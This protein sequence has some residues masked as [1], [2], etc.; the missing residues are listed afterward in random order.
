[1]L[2]FVVLYF[3]FYFCVKDKLSSVTKYIDF[4]LFLC[5]SLLIEDFECIT[6]LNRPCLIELDALNKKRRK[7]F[8]RLELPSF[9][10]KEYENGDRSRSYLMEHINL[11]RTYKSPEISKELRRFIEE[12]FVS[13]ADETQVY[14][15]RDQTR[16][17]CLLNNLQEDNLKRITF[18]LHERW[19]VLTKKDTQKF[20]TTTRIQL[21]HV[22]VVPGGRFQEFFYW[23]T[24]FVLEGLIQSGMKETSI[25]IFENCSTLIE[26]L[27]FIPNGTRK[28]YLNRTQPPFYCLMMESLLKFK[29]ENI[30]KM[31]LERGLKC[32]IT[33]MH[34]FETQKSVII[35]HNGEQ[36]RLFRY[37]VDSD[38]FRLESLKNDLET[39]E[40]AI[41][42]T[43]DQSMDFQERIFSSLKSSAESGIDFSN[44][45]FKEKGKIETIET[46]DIIPV[47]LNALI[48]NNYVFL[49][50]LCK[51]NGNNT[52]A[53]NYT[54]KAQLLHDAIN[55]VFWD[56]SSKCWADY[57]FVKKERKKSCFRP[58]NFYPLFFSIEPPEISHYEI[59]A[60]YSDEIFGDVGGIPASSKEDAPTTEQWD[61]PNVWAPYNYLFFI[62]FRDILHEKK[63]AFH[64]AKCFFDCI[65]KNFEGQNMFF[66]K[67][68]AKSKTDI[69]GGGE[70][71][72]QDGFGWTNGVALCFLT[73]YGDQLAEKFIRK[74]SLKHIQ[75]IL[76]S[77]VISDKENPERKETTHHEET[78]V[79]TVADPVSAKTV[80]I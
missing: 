73:E 9:D 70:Y 68:S 23:D 56:P 64:V 71:D 26:S 24:W 72:T 45:W 44:R 11:I 57:N 51:M 67:Y 16:D 22:F 12:N 75:K 49:A 8:E 19:K 53:S 10:F 63:M 58:S 37:F 6:E 5:S 30:K 41:E 27:G 47:D 40:K 20:P 50:K 4:D 74:E 3:Q 60:K 1:M 79:L 13:S 2:G 28:Y 39:Y 18:A 54:K 46:I 36:K 77:K 29:D 42:R 55:Q 65:E 14:I 21:P 25:G 15:S 80:Q 17:C 33:E 43:K 32:A 34:Y 69:G 61:Y 62:Y 35:D 7:L 31:I 59:I 48:Y 78:C 66:E 38:Y 76:E 52:E